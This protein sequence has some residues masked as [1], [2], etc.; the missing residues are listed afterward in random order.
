MQSVDD[1]LSSFGVRVAD[2]V[3]DEHLLLPGYDY[4]FED[5]VADPPR[6]HSQIPSGFAGAQSLNDAS[7]A[8]TSR[9]LNQVPM[10]RE[11]AKRHRSGRLVPTID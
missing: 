4:H 9:W 2:A 11:F 5:E 6:L 1:R 10:L 8:D 7:R 3:V